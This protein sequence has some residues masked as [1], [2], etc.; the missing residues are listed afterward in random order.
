VKEPFPLHLND[1]LLQRANLSAGT[2]VVQECW[3]CGHRGLA[4][5]LV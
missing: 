5:L 2:D 3:R 4:R 1:P